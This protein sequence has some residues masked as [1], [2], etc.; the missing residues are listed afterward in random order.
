[1]TNNAWNTPTMES[2]GDGYTLIGSA[3]GRPAA[4]LITGDSDV[5]ITAGANTLEISSAASGG[6]LTKI[7]T[8]TASTSASIDFTGL[9]S[10]YFLY[11]L[12][13]SNLQPAT[14]ATTLIL[15]TST[16][17]GSTY[18]SG[19][20][21]YSWSLFQADESGT[22]SGAAD[23]ADSSITVLGEAGSS[24]E[25]GSASNELGAGTI[26]LFNPSATKYTFVF[27]QGTYFNEATQLITNYTGGYRISAADVDAFQLLMDSGNISIGDFVLYGVSNT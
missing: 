7:S 26:Y 23:T 8:A 6:A 19:A 13:Y 18:D 27:C 20:S 24:D 5:T 14:D 15:R 25:M 2:V 21:D 17:G 11:I 22:E 1:M 12:R 10:S 9:T 16:D 3:V 4:A